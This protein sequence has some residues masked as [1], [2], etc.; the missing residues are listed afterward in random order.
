MVFVTIAVLNVAV[1]A[2][3]YSYSG[4]WGVPSDAIIAVEG[5]VIY[6]ERQ[7]I[8]I[9]GRILVPA[10][11]TFELIG[12]RT[13]WYPDHEVVKMINGNNFITMSMGNK[14][15]YVNGK[16]K[17]M[18]APA[19][20]VNG[21]VMVPIRF[22][23]ENFNSSVGWDDKNKM[24]FIGHAAQLPSRGSGLSSD[25]IYRV[26]IDAGHGGSQSGA[27]Y[28]GVKE[29]DL[30]L[31]IAKRLNALLRKE[32]IQTYMTRDNDST[33][34]LYSRS[35]LANNVGADLLVS[36]HNNAGQSK[37]S[38]SMTLYYPGSQKSK[39]NLSSYEFAKI[40]QTNLNKHLGT[41][42]MGVI[43][44]PNLA[45]LRTSNMPAVI[46][47]VGY[48]TNSAE[49]SKLKTEWYRQEAAEAL[50]NAVLQSLNKM[51]Q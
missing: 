2:S 49:L 41:K 10:R 38:G 35:G 4:Y 33:V 25:R 20:L 22:V 26:V 28:G 23:A 27:V 40:V 32:G 6:P 42:D 16:V 45:V 18:E 15:A 37:A 17:Y 30:N 44:R 39:G 8:T 11:S 24:A 5:T 14:A 1:F 48:M 29:K 21:T 51:Y 3:G 13:D 12:V 46:A 50:R 31:D 47:E 43:K 36:I 7:P 9:D 34:S 19:V